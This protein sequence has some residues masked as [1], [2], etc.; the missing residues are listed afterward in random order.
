MP[1]LRSSHPIRTLVSDRSPAHRRFNRTDF[2]N[3][4]DLGEVI[5]VTWLRTRLRAAQPDSG[6]SLIEV[7]V[8][9]LVFAIIAIGVGYSTV[10]IVKLTDDTRS[11]QVA[12]GLATSAIDLARSIEDPFDIVN[13]TT[14]QVVGD[15]TYTIARSTSWV[16]TSGADVGCGT[17]TGT[18]QAKRIN[19]TVTW[20]GMLSTTQPVRSDSLIAP[21]TRIN[22][23][24]RGTIRIS[25]LGVDGVGEEGV[26]VTV[27]P[28][29][30]GAVLTEQPDATN[31]DGCSFALKVVP[32]TYSVTVSRSGSV[33]QNQNAAPSTSVVVTA[34]GSVA[35]QFQYDYA[36]L[37]NLI[38]A[39]N[40]S[41]GGLRLPTNLETT[42]I[43]SAGTSVISGRPSQISLHPYSSGYS[44]VTGRYIAPSQ[45]SAGC[46]NVDPAAW[47]AATVSGTALAAGV[48]EPAVA[49]PPQGTTTMNI[50]MGILTVRHTTT[51]FLTAVSATAPAAAADP[52][53]ATAMTLSFGQV[54][55]NGNTVVALPWGSWNLYSHSTANGIR[56]PIVGGSITTN[57]R[58]FLSGNTVTLDPRRPV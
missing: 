18:L 27:T 7:I 31:A 46:V 29:T 56:T 3:R 28:T 12:T 55:T 8:A 53:C 38:Y 49:A 25:V 51:A 34:G 4:T 40:Y 45:S 21:D 15:T 14:T 41:G 26:S 11:R 20:A 2:F 58:A 52:G 47:P 32:G 43:T 54:L 23:P 35:A 42:F 6:V 57:V 30:G 48:R 24:A 16:E 44:G 50:P 10:T 36:G 13:L 39:S 22:D 9:M 1:H 37:Y 33:D 17:G 19:V 5:A